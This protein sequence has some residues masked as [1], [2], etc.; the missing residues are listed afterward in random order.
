[1]TTHS[2]IGS[3]TCF[4]QPSPRNLQA[5]VIVSHSLPF[6]ATI[7][8]KRVPFKLGTADADGLCHDY[9]D[10]FRDVGYVWLAVA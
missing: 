9:D 8:A 3:V 10:I 1:M 7:F 6:C 4:T 2:A 5:S